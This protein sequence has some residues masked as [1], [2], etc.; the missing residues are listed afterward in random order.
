[1]ELVLPESEFE[2]ELDDIEPIL[3]LLRNPSSILVTLDLDASLINDNKATL[4]GF[5]LCIN[6]SVENLSLFG[7][8]GSI[9]STGWNAIFLGLSNPNHSLEYLDIGNNQFGGNLTVA[10]KSLLTNNKLLTCLKLPSTEFE[11]NCWHILGEYLL[12]SDSILE[13]LDVSEAN[14][15]N[16]MVV[17]LGDVL[18]R[19]QH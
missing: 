13:Y 5:A 3:T 6:T 11:N 9:T 19:V 14:I 10:F 18:E 1:M 16:D 15:I 4:L 7:M 17:A 8:G 2:R 12:G